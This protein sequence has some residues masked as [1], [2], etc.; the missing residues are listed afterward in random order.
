VSAHKTEIVGLVPRLAGSDVSAY[1]AKVGPEV[2]RASSTSVVAEGV[3]PVIDMLVSKAS[4]TSVVA[5]GVA[6]AASME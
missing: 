5:E 6:L 3:F 2:S 4:S 1:T